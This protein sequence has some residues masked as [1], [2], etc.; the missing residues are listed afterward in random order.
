MLKR[1]LLLFLV[2][3]TFSVLLVRV[4]AAEFIPFC[5]ISERCD[6]T[7]SCSNI[8]NGNSHRAK[9][10]IDP[11]DKPRPNSKVYVIVG[12]STA[13]GQHYTSGSTSI[14]NFFTYSSMPSS[15]GYRFDGLFREDGITSINQSLTYTLKTNAAG[16]LFTNDGAP[17]SAMEWEDWTPG[18][19][20]R[21][22][23]GISEVQPTPTVNPNLGRG[24]Q[25]QATVLFDYNAA[26]KKCIAVAWDP[27]GVVFD[28]QSLEPIPSASVTLTKK[29]ADGTFS[30]VNKL[31]PNDVPN[32]ILINPFLT[33]EDGGFSFFVPDGTYKLTPQI[34]GYNFPSSLSLNSNY[35]KIYSNIYP[36][37]TGVEIVEKGGPQHRDIPVDSVSGQPT[38]FPIK[39]IE[40]NYQSDRI[41]SVFID[42]RV[43]HPLST[44]NAYSVIPD[45]NNPGAKIRYKLIKTVQADKVG[46]FS[47]IVNQS[48]FD[49][50]KSEMF[51][52]IE[53]I[54]ANFGGTSTDTNPAPAILK[55]DPILTY[56]EGGATD[57]KGQALPGAKIELLLNFATKPYYETM[58]D[59]QGYFKIPSDYI[60]FMPYKLRYSSGGMIINATTS[61]FLTDNSANLNSNKTNLFYPQYNNPKINANIKKSIVAYNNQLNSSQEKTSNNNQSQFSNPTTTNNNQPVSKNLTFFGIVLFIV[62]LLVIVGVLGVYLI[63][64]NQNTSTM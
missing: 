59:S 35:S 30:F 42:G 50:T 8:G 20:E 4:S 58:A 24:G 63:K 51:G 48:T 15:L 52:E 56:I 17:I 38:Y 49:K 1:F 41:S 32:G 14:D 11:Q 53:A 33:I 7:Q 60:P 39:I 64:K 44:I 23:F 31:D 12:I 21:R 13:D 61:K 16:A 36:L 47:I 46:R 3:F 43:S 54:K 37:A 34:T 27:D 5:F 57:D 6:Q 40:Y 9:L 18:T 55:L 29:R 45:P 25:Q 22:F 2:F 26:L 10:T 62:I 28:S 19:H